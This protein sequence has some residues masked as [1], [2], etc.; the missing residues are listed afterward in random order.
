MTLLQQNMRRLVNFTKLKLPFCFFSF[1][2]TLEQALSF[3]QKE[4]KRVPLIIKSKQKKTGNS[5]KC[6]ILKVDAYLQNPSFGVR[7]KANSSK[8]H[9]ISD[10]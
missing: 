10:H 7:H 2:T 8:I 6:I 9:Q 3:G 4:K 1:L 5:K